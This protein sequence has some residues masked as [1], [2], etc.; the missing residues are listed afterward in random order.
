MARSPCDDRVLEA[1]RAKAEAIH[2]GEA[3]ARMDADQEREQRR[4]PGYRRLACT[5][6]EGCASLRRSI[7]GHVDRQ[8]RVVGDRWVAV[9]FVDT[10]ACELRCC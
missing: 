9:V 1:R 7:V 8:A 10:A 2:S 4:R 5:D 3:I 6:R